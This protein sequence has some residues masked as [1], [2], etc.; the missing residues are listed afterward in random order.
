MTI[1]Q[2]RLLASYYQRPQPSRAITI[3]LKPNKGRRPPPPQ[4]PNEAFVNG[5]KLAVT[6]SFISDIV[7]HN[8]PLTSLLCVGAALL[9]IVETEPMDDI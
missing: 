3:A 8:F 1:I 4:K 5:A 6:M 7:S 2:P 9:C